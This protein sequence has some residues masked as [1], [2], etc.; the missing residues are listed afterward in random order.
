MLRIRVAVIS[1]FFTFAFAGG[2]LRLADLQINRTVELAAFR[3]R[4]LN[5]IE[6]KAPRRG[7]ILDAAG[8]IIAED[9]PTQDIWLLPARLEPVGRRRIVVSNLSP[10]SVEQLLLLAALRGEE[11][12]FERNLALTSLAEAN[13]LVANLADRL[14]IDRLEAAG[15]VLAAA[16]SGN[17]ASADDLTY[18][19]LAFEDVDFAL[20]L[21][22]RSAISNPFN[23]G[24]W[25]A[26]VMRTGGKRHYPYGSIFGHLT[27]AVGKLSSEEYLELRGRWDGD[28]AVP[29]KSVIRKLDRVF[30]SI[31]GDNGEPSDEELIL[32]LKE[33]RRAGK[34]IK[35]Q[36]YLANEMVGRGGLEQYYNQALRGRHRL[37][38]LR[39]TRNPRNGRRGFVPSGGAK[40]AVNG[41]DLRLSLRADIQRQTRVILESHIKQIARRPELVASGWT[42]SGAA[43]MLNPRNG[44]IHAMVSL[45]SY[46]PNTFNRDFP[47]LSDDPGKPLL[48]RA[49]AGIYPPGSVVK[50]LVGMAALAND[51]IMPGQHFFC[52]HILLLGGAKFTCLGR[53]GEQD[54]ESALMHS[55]NIFFYH[56]GEALG[57]RRLYEWY[58][59]VGL[60]RRAGIDLAGEAA[61]ILPRNAYTRQGWATGNTYHLAIGQGMAITPL[62]MAVVYAALANAEGGVMRI[63]RPHLMIPSD[64]PPETDEEEDW[65]S[66]ALELDQPVAETLVDREALALVR[67]GMWE[68]VQGK[69]ETGEIGTGHQASFPLPGGGFLIE[70][71]GK[72]GT[73]EWSRNVG[74][75]A[76]KQISH[77]W[78][79]AFAPFDRPE[80][81]AV[82]LLPEAGGGGGGTCAPIVKDL[83][84][85]WFNLPERINEVVNDAEALG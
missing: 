51:A 1:L 36:G 8:E 40:A 81:A 54:I 80:V 11:G 76:L 69:P 65:A 61:G 23:D 43:I 60:G 21:E 6:Q 7:R 52:D 67:Q 59:R 57:G 44:R 26:I 68:A 56:A 33:V 39:L 50:P 53:H 18:S 71:G 2:V 62:Q 82:V 10:L 16:L 14:R 22:I 12:Q 45:P 20:S 72:T 35:T 75:N 34:T 25:R 41:L 28:V 5:Q 58:A 63:V 84:R 77:V 79:A 15:K 70:I 27:G 49:I 64:K 47:R 32:G 13:P 46:D 78:F 73:A 24:A 4:R 55:C 17:P 74:G 30:F 3:D 29:G 48:D 83:F 37:Q 31:L 19:R 42:P 66:E 85:M 38:R 9:R